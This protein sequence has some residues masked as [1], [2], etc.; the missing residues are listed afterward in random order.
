RDRPDDALGI[1]MDLDGRSHRPFHADAVGAHD[2]P[3][4]FA[5]RAGHADPDGVG[6]LVAELEDVA[7]LDAALH[8]ERPPADDARLAGGGLAQV[9]PPAD[10]D[11][12]FDVDATQVRV[13]D[14]GAGVHAAP[15]AQRPV[16]DDRVISDA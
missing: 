2:R 16:G 14:V 15:P 7:D 12:P 3:D 8:L 10:G 1:V 6:E 11:V 5:V 13:V 9:R 4:R